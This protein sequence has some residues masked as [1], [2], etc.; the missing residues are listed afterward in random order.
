M[1]DYEFTPNKIDHHVESVQLVVQ[2][3]IDAKADRVHLQ[4]FYN[5]ASER[6]PNLFDT[7]NQR[8]GTFEIKK[9]LVVAGKGQVEVPTFTLIPKGPLLSF[10]RKLPFLQDDVRW[11]E[12]LVA[13]VLTCVSTLLE[14][15][16]TLKILQVIKRRD[17]IFTTELRDSSSVIRD[18]F[19]GRLPAHAQDVGVRWN[20][21]DDK[22]DRLITLNAVRRRSLIIQ[23]VDGLPYRRQAPTGEYGIQVVLD[24]ASRPIRRPLAPEQLEIILNHA[25]SYYNETLFNALNGEGDANNT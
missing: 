3:P 14:C 2:P 22:Y 15:L 24:V 11:S 20:D 10:P 13:D 19:A 21:R 17:L 1:I 4:E 5:R 6:L 7:L 9:L 25:D 12:N 16:R 23:T 8:P 18:R